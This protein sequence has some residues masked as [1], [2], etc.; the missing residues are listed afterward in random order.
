MNVI[1][2]KVRLQTVLRTLGILI[3]IVIL[4]SSDDIIIHA[5]PVGPY[6]LIV[7]CCDV[8]FC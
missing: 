7:V 2:D 1:Y 6:Q 3:F 4:S 8:W 5:P